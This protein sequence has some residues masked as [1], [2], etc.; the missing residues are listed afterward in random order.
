MDNERG[1]H[2]IPLGDKDQVVIR[3]QREKDTSEVL[4][5]EIVFWSVLV[6]DDPFED[7]GLSYPPELSAIFPSE[8]RPSYTGRT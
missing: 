2:S 4:N 5:C 3:P 6:D 8:S 1:L 7:K